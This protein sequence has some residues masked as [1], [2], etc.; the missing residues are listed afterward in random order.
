M[1]VCQSS[2]YYIYTCT[3]TVMAWSHGNTCIYNSI[4]TQ[5]YTCVIEIKQYIYNIHVLIGH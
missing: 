1:T 5:I 4:E 2:G 3:I